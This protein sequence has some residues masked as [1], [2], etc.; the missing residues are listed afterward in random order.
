MPSTTVHVL[1]WQLEHPSND[2]QSKSSTEL[3]LII[4]YMNKATVQPELHMEVGKVL[5]ND[6]PQVAACTCR[7]NLLHLMLGPFF[8]SFIDS[9]E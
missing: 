8:F 1:L 9:L 5:W 2:I 4:Y 6:L 7:D 3:A